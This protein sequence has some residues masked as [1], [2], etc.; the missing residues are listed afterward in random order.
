MFIEFFYLLRARGLG[1]DTTEWMTLMEGLMRGLHGNSL[2]GFY[3][4]CR[5]TLV[6]TEADYDKFDMVFAE[7]FKDVPY[8]GELPDMVKEWLSNKEEALKDFHAFLKTSDYEWKTQE[9]ILKAFEER[10]REQREE[11]NAGSYW[12]G[13]GGFTNFGHSGHRPQGIRIMGEGRYRRAFEVLGERRFRDFRKDNVLDIR[14]FQMAFR[15]LRQYSDRVN[16]AETEFDTDGTIRETADNAGNLRIKYKK[17]RKNVVK[18]LLLMDSGGSMDY[19]AGICSMLFQA[20]EK[21]NHFKE[22]HVYYFH[23]VIGST[24]YK[25]PMLWY[26]DG[27]STEWVLNQYGSEYKV[28]LVGDALMD[29]YDLVAKHYDR[30]LGEARYSGFDMLDRFKEH[31][32]HIVWLNPE[33][34]PYG[35]YKSDDPE[36][37]WCLG[38]KGTILPKYIA[39]AG[40]RGKGLDDAGYGWGGG[41]GGNWGESYG[42]I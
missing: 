19:Y 18:V 10:L 4:L 28:I 35:A 11:H 25:R 30:S 3:N 2:S 5:A 36:K 17:P 42:R 21:S 13:T 14:S 26:E 16:E 33:K 41:Y 39:A 40:Q 15:L 27:V 29:M 6:K 12:I 8:E 20:A 37:A 24:L 38:P 32:P 9:E 1:T 31:Y 34:P 22:L 7:Y 23:N